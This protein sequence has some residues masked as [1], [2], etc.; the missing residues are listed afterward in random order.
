MMRILIGVG[1]LC[2]LHLG[3]MCAQEKGVNK[4]VSLSPDGV[5]SVDTFKGSVTVTSWDNPQVQI[6]AR[7]E[8]DGAST[9]G[10]EKVQNT[11]ISIDSSPSCVRIKC[12]YSKARRQSKF[13]DVFGGDHGNLPFVHYRCVC[14]PD[15]SLCFDPRPVELA[16]WCERDGPGHVRG[17]LVA[18]D[19]DVARSQLHS[20][21]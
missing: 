2:L 5:V 15:G 1:M 20:R 4:T 3:V 14:R 21:A 12:D 11:E 16:V 6:H 13:L 18:V 10:K 7:I 9:E 17:R 19:R 8:P